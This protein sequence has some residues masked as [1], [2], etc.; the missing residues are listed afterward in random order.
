MTITIKNI[1]IFLGSLSDSV[2]LISPFV[3]ILECLCKREFLTPP[4]ERRIEVGLL[5]YV[6]MQVISPRG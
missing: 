3:R 4:M 6:G 1:H 5:V 2:P